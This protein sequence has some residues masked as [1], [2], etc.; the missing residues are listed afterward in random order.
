MDIFRYALFANGSLRALCLL[1][2]TACAAR[3]DGIRVGNVSVT[4]RVVSTANITFDIAWS[5]SWR[6][7]V[8]HDAAWVFLKVRA[9]GNADWAPVR[10]A[11]DRVLNP[12]GF[13]QEKGALV[14]TNGLERPWTPLEFVV[15]TG[16]DGGLGLLI[17]RTEG[18]MGVVETRPVTVV[19]DFAANKGIA[20]DARASVAAFAV[21]MVYVPEGAFYL[22]SGEGEAN[23][24]YAY[25]DGSQNTNC[26]RVTGP[27]AIATGRQAGRLWATSVTPA[28]NGELP[29]SYPNGYAA[30]YCMK[31][32]YLTQGQY[33]GFLNCLSP[34][35]AEVRYRADR[36]GSAIKRSATA[37]A[38]AYSTLTPDQRCPWLTW[39]D[40]LTFAAWAGLRPMTELEYEK[41]GRGLGTPAA[42][43]AVM[44]YWG[45]A[46]INGGET[47][48]RTISVG[49]AAARKFAGTHGRGTADLP[50][51]W[52]TKASA[53]ICRS[54]AAD[55]HTG[56]NVQPLAGWRAVR[57]APPGDADLGPA[58]VPLRDRKL[59]FARLKT[60]GVAD[61]DLKEWGKPTL[62]LKTP[63]DCYSE[64]PRFSTGVTARGWQGPSDLGVD[65]YLGWD[66]DSL[67]I[68]ADVTDDRHFNTRS[69]DGIWDGDALQMGIDT[70]DGSGTI[71]ALALTT[72]G[73]VFHQFEG[74]GAKLATNAGRNVIRDE[75]AGKTRY[76]LTL[77]LRELGIRAGATIGY[78]L[79]IFDDDN[80]KGQRYWFQLGPGITY[81]FD[82]ER[83]PRFTLEEK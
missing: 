69:G 10:L 26:Y 19:W 65:L 49:S 35:Q 75:E 61:G 77:P 50:G 56:V 31:Y 67:C 12:T 79:M 64:K 7:G 18:G 58:P 48:E 60:K 57:T 62:S 68:A 45:A 74:R 23:R 36:H 78:N 46:P 37:A 2:L 25:S 38:A 33:A 82:P 66:G 8:V 22:G 63:L 6:Y 51:D 70:G 55:A 59:G 16:E 54:G 34:A 53:V 81:P 5:I 41:M 39:E 30:F 4:S 71:F 52:P 76:E 72:N 13:G 1:V 40:A 32:P 83:F 11:A 73:V 44:S 27:G 28:D 42:D 43:D 14:S 24:F 15:P 17:R 80:G 9:G 20:R 3:A 21:E 47:G 29:A